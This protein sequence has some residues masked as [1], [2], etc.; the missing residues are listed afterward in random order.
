MS[1][2]LTGVATALVRTW[3]WIY[4]CGTPVFVRDGR[5]REIE[6]DLWEQQHDLA[7]DSDARVAAEIM[8]RMLAG[9]LD[10]MQW[11]VEHRALSPRRTQALIAGTLA[12][13]FGAAWAYTATSQLFN[14]QP[15]PIPSLM[16]FVA[17]QP[18]RP[19][20]PPPPPA[21]QAQMSER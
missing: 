3:T 4:T 9:I 17:A 14:E 2:P 5:R 13:I 19:P 1:A 7:G 11:R 18:P 8:L 16:S 20:P 10:D 15:P 12:I 6:S 21:P